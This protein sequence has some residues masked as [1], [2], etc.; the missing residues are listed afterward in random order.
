MAGAGFGESA[1]AFIILVLA[2]RI[3]V[4]L[5]GSPTVVPSRHR[6]SL[7]SGRWRRTY[8]AVV[9]H[10]HIALDD[11]SAER[12]VA[13]HLGTQGLAGKHR[14]RETH[15]QMSQLLRA[16]VGEPAQH[17]VECHAEGA[18][19]MQD[20]PR[21]AGPQRCRGLRVERVVVAVEAVVQ[22]L[23]RTGRQVESQVGR[24][25][26]QAMRHFR[27]LPGT[28]EAAVAA[29]EGGA[30]GDS[31]HLAAERV[32]EH[33]LA[34]EQ[35]ALVGALV[36]QTGDPGP[37]DHLAFRRQRPPPLQA[38]LAVNQAQR[39]HA[40]RRIAQ[41]EA[42]MTEHQGHARQC[43]EIAARIDVDQLALVQRVAAQTEGQCVE[44]AVAPAVALA[45]FGDRVVQEYLRIE[46]H[47]PPPRLPT[48]HPPPRRPGP[49]ARR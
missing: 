36:Y 9:Q 27:H 20:R 16:V 23:L 35:R 10:H 49:P 31:Q 28:T 29:K 30:A 44:G 25:F 43:L 6:P 41:P 22:G 4:D 32:A 5:H 17:R 15:L 19:A 33:L 18:Q 46:R 2:S 39:V 48:P 42:R 47:R 37:T 12:A 26:R 13:P 45:Y 21:E 38:L 34:V 8:P 1:V 40:S 14:S 7:Q 11:A 3:S 24:P